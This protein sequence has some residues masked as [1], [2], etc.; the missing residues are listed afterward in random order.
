MAAAVTRLAH[1][2]VR[3]AADPRSRP[4]PQS[5][6]CSAI[7]RK[8]TSAGVRRV[9]G[10]GFQS[11]AEA[12]RPFEPDLARFAGELESIEIGDSVLR[13]G[14]QGWIEHLR[15]PRRHFQPDFCTALIRWRAQG[16]PPSK[17]PVDPEVPNLLD[18]LHG[19]LRLPAAAATM[20]ALGVDRNPAEAFAEGRRGV[21]SSGLLLLDAM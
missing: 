2:I 8:R 20:R 21:L 11:P 3:R 12:L 16:F 17:R 5:P 9:I 4:R 15:R 6:E 7:L 14:A 18:D 1:A 13:A 10:A 19:D